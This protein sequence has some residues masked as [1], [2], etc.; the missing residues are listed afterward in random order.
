[1]L[2]G[3]LYD[4]IN[5]RGSNGTGE[6]IHKYTEKKVLTESSFVFIILVFSIFSILLLLFLLD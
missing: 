4:P 3:Y 1:M 5:C 6:S 2:C